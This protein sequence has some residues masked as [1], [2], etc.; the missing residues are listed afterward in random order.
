MAFLSQYTYI[1][2]I[3]LLIYVHCTCIPDVHVLRFQHVIF[4]VGVYGVKRLAGLGK[5]KRWLTAHLS[6]F[7]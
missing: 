4:R 3:K 2:R 1:V 6:S 5:V 7:T